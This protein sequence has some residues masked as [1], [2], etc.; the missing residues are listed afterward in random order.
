[1]RLTD[2]VLPSSRCSH[3][4]TQPAA[5]SEA[6]A[7]NRNSTASVPTTWSHLARLARGW[8]ALTSKCSCG[9]RKGFGNSGEHDFASPDNML[10]R[11]RREVTLGSPL[12]HFWLFSGWREIYRFPNGSPQ[13]CRLHCILAWARFHSFDICYWILVLEA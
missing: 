4:Q 9:Q 5:Q 3:S 6:L 8:H 1:M 12:T 10:W 2:E 7:C 13:H 11:R